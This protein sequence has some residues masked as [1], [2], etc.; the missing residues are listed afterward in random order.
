[1]VAFLWHFPILQY[2]HRL[3]TFNSVQILAYA[4]GHVKKCHRKAKQATTL[5]EPFLGDTSLYEPYLYRMADSCTI[6]LFKAGT[7]E[8]RRVWTAYVKEMFSAERGELR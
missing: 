4:E 5:P 2:R 3:I 6:T 8:Y 1:V 7:A